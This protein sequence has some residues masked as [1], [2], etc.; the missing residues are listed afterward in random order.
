M[1]AMPPMKPFLLRVPESMMDEIDLIA[2]ETY[3]T[4]SQFIR[5]S[6]L[7]NLEI[8]KMEMALLR[9]HYKESDL[10]LLRVFDATPNR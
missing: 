10:R 9:N 5:Q 8:S 6:I 4:K 3:T 1:K 2:G 7:R